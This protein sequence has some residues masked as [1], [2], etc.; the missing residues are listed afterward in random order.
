MERGETPNRPAFCDVPVLIV[1]GSPVEVR[2]N[3]ASP[4]AVNTY[5]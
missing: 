3:E 4:T 1:S 2:C 5:V